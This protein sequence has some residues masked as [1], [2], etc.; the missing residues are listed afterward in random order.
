M[1]VKL[2]KDKMPFLSNDIKEAVL[3]SANIAGLYMI[4]T[5]EGFKQVIKKNE[6]DQ[7]IN[8]NKKLEDT[9]RNKKITKKDLNGYRQ[10]LEKHSKPD[11]LVIAEKFYGNIDTYL[12][13][14][15][16]IEL[17]LKKEK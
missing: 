8:F 9:D 14:K 6:Y 15:E 4:K 11:L 17:I 10:S 2:S 16:I 12:T 1:E 7:I 5:K 3:S 13:K